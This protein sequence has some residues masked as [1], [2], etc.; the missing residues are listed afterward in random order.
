MVTRNIRL[1][2]IIRP[3]RSARVLVHVRRSCQAPRQLHCVFRADLGTDSG[4]TGDHRALRPVAAGV[5]GDASGCVRISIVAV[6]ARI[7]PRRSTS[8]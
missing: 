6:V 2:S 8:R 1:G 5:A 7:S 4:L 3:V